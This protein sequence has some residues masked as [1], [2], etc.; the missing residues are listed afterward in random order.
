MHPLEVSVGAAR[1][2][3]L[4]CSGERV[5]RA[6]KV[7]LHIYNQQ[8][9]MPRIEIERRLVLKPDDLQ[10]FFMLVHGIS[11]FSRS[12]LMTLKLPPAPGSESGSGRLVRRIIPPG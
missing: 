5:I 11:P 8:R 7:A 12:E 2:E 9:R 6:Y 1:N 4:Q 10:N 3:P